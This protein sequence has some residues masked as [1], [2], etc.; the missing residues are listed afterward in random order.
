MNAVAQEQ[1]RKEIPPVERQRFDLALLDDLIDVR[2]IGLQQGRPAA[3]FDGLGQG[4]EIERGVR[5]QALVDN[6]CQGADDLRLES[7]PLDLQLIA[8]D[9]QV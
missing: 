7:V 2:L 6:Q 3:D 8:A 9:R 4:A 1:E 5:T